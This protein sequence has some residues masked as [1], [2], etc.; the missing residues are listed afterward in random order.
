MHYLTRCLACGVLFPASHPAEAPCPSCGV[1]RV[2]PP[3]A[4]W[5]KSVKRFLI[6]QLVARTLARHGGD[7]DFAWRHLLAMT[8]RF[9][10]LP[11]P[12]GPSVAIPMAATADEVYPAVLRLAQE[13]EARRRASSLPPRNAPT[14]ESM[15]RQAGEPPGHA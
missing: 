12:S 13:M 11:M 3:V 8:L 9:T 1:A 10:T 6:E 7:T 15:D 14:N 5:P 2:C 4:A